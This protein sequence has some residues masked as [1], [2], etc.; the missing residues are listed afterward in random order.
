V[1]GFEP[2]RRIVGTPNKIHGDKKSHLLWVSSR[3]GVETEL[4]GMA[5]SVISSKVTVSNSAILLPPVKL[6]NRKSLAI[7]VPASLSGELWI[8][9]PGVTD[10]NGFPIQAGLY[11]MMDAE[12]DVYGFS[13]SEVDIRLLEGA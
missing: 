7:Y 13:L 9:G 4:R 1:P 5:E 6:V 8:G 10:D 12:A 3:G 11:S 2:G